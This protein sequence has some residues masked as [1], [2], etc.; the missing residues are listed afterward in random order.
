MKNT[1]PYYEDIKEGMQLPE[2]H[3]GPITTDMIVHFVCSSNNFHPIH[4]DKDIAR[5]EGHPDVLAHG[6]LKL[7]LFDRLIREWVGD[8]GILKRIT[9]TYSRPNY[10]GDTL[11]IT[12]KVSY[13]FLEK[14][15][16]YVECEIWSKNQKE[17]INTKGT[18]LIV[19]PIKSRKIL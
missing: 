2:I 12:G 14:G 5:A 17:K 8:S 19:L 7:A 6:P 16:G 11:I 10:P 13:T 18:A 15:E 3:Y 9:A 4:Y 1:Q